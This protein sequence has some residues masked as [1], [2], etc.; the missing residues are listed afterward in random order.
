MEQNKTVFKTSTTRK[1]YFVRLIGRCIVLALAIGLYI[2]APKQFSVAEGMAFFTCFSPLHL[3]W[4]IW[5]ADMIIQL[6]P[7]KAHI[8]IGS[9]KLFRA[10]FIPIRKRINVA[11]LKMYIRNTTYAAYK[12]MLIWIVLISIIICDIILIIVVIV[13]IIISLIIIWI[14]NLIIIIILILFIISCYT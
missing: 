9:Q 1:I 8:S 12:V 6:M 13:V 3:L 10:L 11:N 4:G 5:I 2:F 7:V 14:L